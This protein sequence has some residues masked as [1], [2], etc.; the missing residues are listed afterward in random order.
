MFSTE[1][2]LQ[3]SARISAQ[4]KLSFHLQKSWYVFFFFFHQ[5]KLPIKAGSQILVTLHHGTSW[6]YPWVLNLGFADK[7]CFVLVGFCS[8]GP[9]IV[10]VYNPLGW[11]R[12]EYI[13][14]PLK[15]LVSAFPPC[16]LEAAFC[17]IQSVFF[18][19]LQLPKRV[20]FNMGM[21]TMHLSTLRQ[22]KFWWAWWRW[23]TGFECCIGGHWHGG[24]FNPISACPTSQ[25]SMYRLRKLYVA[26]NDVSVANNSPP[27]FH[28][29]FSGVVPPLGYIQHSEFIKHHHLLLPVTL[30][31]AFLSMR[32]F[33]VNP[34]HFTE[35]THWDGRLVSLVL[36]HALWCKSRMLHKKIQ[37][38]LLGEP[39]VSMESSTTEM[40]GAST[41]VYLTSG[42]IELNFSGTTGLLTQLPTQ[43]QE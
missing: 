12:E 38:R 17:R 29:V 35:K 8:S 19:S 43:T 22:W 42:R 1:C 15:N 13:R 31:R 26:A 37:W 21:L 4:L 36:L 23:V 10:V 20:P 6:I 40:L 28:L 41:I 14:S 25:V 27:R 16:N 7:N 32:L 9:K 33:F 2:Q 11:T 3:I 18:Y 30:V 5:K 24:Q 34:S 39:D